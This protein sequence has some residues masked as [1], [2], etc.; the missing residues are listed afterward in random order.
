MSV[1]CVHGDNV[2][3]PLANVQ[4]VVVDGKSYFVEAAVVK[5]LPTSVLFGRDVPTF[6]SWCGLAH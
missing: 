1:Q 5:K 4:E 3:Y 2:S 6:L